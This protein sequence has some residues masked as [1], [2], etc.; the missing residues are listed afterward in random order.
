MQ[1]LVIV[2]VTGL[3]ATGTVV[4]V[5]IGAIVSEGQVI[6]IVLAQDGR[7]VGWVILDAMEEF[8]SLSSACS[9][10]SFHYVMLLKLS[11]WRS[12]VV[13]VRYIMV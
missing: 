12:R 9:L 2:I 11:S 8:C 4:A 6:I 7:I 1:F 13:V 3:N 10:N 5:A